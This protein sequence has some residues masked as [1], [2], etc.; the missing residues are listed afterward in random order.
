MAVS[1]KLKKTADGKEGVSLE[2]V[3]PP[4]GVRITSPTPVPKYKCSE[5]C[6]EVLTIVSDHL[7]AFTA[8]ISGP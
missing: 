1:S 6:G 5:P 2:I 7:E 3:P 8:I 4:R